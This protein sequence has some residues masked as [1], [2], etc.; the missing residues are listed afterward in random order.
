VASDKSAVVPRTAL[1]WEAHKEE[2]RRKLLASARRLFAERGF[3]ATSAADI[4]ADAG[5]TER[6]LFRY[7]S[8]KVALILDE[9][10]SQIPEMFEVIRNRPAEEPPYEA[11]RQGIMAFIKGRDLLFVQVVG[12]P[13]A[14]DL[15]F[16]DRQRTL[17]DFEGALAEV[18][19]DRYRLPAE[20]QVTAAVWARASIGAMRTALAILAQTRTDEG[21]PEGSFAETLRACFDALPG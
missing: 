10:I 21:V 1:R 16:D 15:P 12:A 8:S 18:L 9:A 19:R 11:V 7:F 17:I 20:D 5:V 4:A 2:T 3:Q 6:T 13:G 14:I